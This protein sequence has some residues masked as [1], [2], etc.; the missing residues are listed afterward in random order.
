MKPTKSSAIGLT[1]VGILFLVP[2]VSRAIDGEPLSFTP[3]VAAATGVFLGA[4]VN[5]ILAVRRKSGGPSGPP[6]A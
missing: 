2:T 4:V 6:S 5:F 1:L 3:G